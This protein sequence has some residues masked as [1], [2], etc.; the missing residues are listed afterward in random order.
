MIQ[1]GEARY[2]VETISKTA[3]KA[4]QVAKD[5]RIRANGGTFIRDKVTRKL[6]DVSSI[7]TRIEEKFVRTAAVL[8]LVSAEA[9]EIA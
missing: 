5:V 8:E 7:P 1:A 9:I 6:I 4:A 2:L 3:D